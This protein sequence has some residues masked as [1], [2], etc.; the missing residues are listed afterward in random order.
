MIKHIATILVI[1][2][3]F[4]CSTST[5]KESEN[6]SFKV[7]SFSQGKMKKVNEKWVI[8]E[9]TNDMLYEV[10]DKCIYNKKEVKCLRH[11]FI[12]SYDSKG[13]DVELQCSV[14]TNI[15]VDAGNIEQVKK[16]DTYEDE[17]RMPLKGNERE[18]VNVQYIDGAAGFSDLLLE[19][20]C[21][22]AGKKVLNFSQ[23]VRMEK[24]KT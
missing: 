2:T 3:L 20:S 10:N 13:A 8:Y 1:L 19:T 14:R 4:S 15:K 18:F 12:I 7:L 16:T 6:E 9:K 11:G 17:F 24:P 21:S 22:F 5:H 23:K